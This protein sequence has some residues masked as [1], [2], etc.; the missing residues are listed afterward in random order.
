MMLAASRG[1]ARVNSDRTTYNNSHVSGGNA[2]NF[3]CEADTNLKGGTASAQQ[4][5]TDR[6]QSAR[7]GPP[8]VR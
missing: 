6:S 7:R 4:V 2:V 5:T 1:Q 3:S 8:F